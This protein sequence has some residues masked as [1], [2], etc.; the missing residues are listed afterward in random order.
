MF[1]AAIPASGAEM[2]SSIPAT[3][4][5]NVPSQPFEAQQTSEFGDRVKFAVGTGGRVR[6]VTV[7][8]SS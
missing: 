6:S 4:P 1:A 3:L 8:M 5:G 7:V 2:Y